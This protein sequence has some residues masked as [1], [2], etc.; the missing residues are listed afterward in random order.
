MARK[1]LITGA[2]VAGP[3]LAFWLARAGDDVTVLERAPAFRDGGQNIDVRGAGREVLV[4]MGLEKTVKA[5]GTGERGI[6]FVKADDTT[7][8]AFD[9]A[10]FG[11]DGPTAELEILRGDLARILVEASEGQGAAYRYGDH[12]AGFE[13]SSGGVEVTFAEGG[14]ER[15]DAVIAA[16]GVASSTRTLLL[17][18]DAKREPIGLYMAYF[19]IPKGRGDDDRAR[20]YAA[21]G[22]RSLLLRPDRYGTTRAVLV[23]RIDPCGLE[24]L[25]ADDQRAAL[26]ER[27]ADAG[28]E[29]ARVLDGMREAKDFYFET[30]GQVH[31]DRW[32]VGRVALVGDAAWATGP[33]TGMGT[34]LGLIGG[35]VLAGELS[36][37][38]A[39]PEAFAAYERVMRPIAEKG[40]D[41][42]KFGPRFLQPSTRFG[43]MV[44]HAVLRAAA[45]TPVRALTSR[46]F[47]GGDDRPS[48]PD[49]GS[50]DSPSLKPAA[51]IS[52]GAT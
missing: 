22:G 43:I 52:A 6:R 35:Y 14:R 8:A 42:P 3:A 28:W 34:S 27:F 2:S 47:A 20:W 19:T 51:D 40:Q 10:E 5:N 16:E 7:A 23:L 24:D 33:I 45:S 17:G 44:Q 41:Y 46:F 11:A 1:I 49:Y 25:N 32:S 30:V 31:L 26:A 37:T 50:L 29:A 39:I 48:L 4:R 21:P 18:R 12:V 36:Q 15:F 38:R 9:Q 13:Q